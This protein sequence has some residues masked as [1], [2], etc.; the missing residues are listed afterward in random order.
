MRRLPR[1]GRR[2][3]IGRYTDGWII[4]VEWLGWILEIRIARRVAASAAATAISRED[5]S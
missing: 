2:R 4:T 3:L 5:I 1:I